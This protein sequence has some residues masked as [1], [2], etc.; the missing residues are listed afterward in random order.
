M[1]DAINKASVTDEKPEKPKDQES[2]GKILCSD[3]VRKIQNPASSGI[4]S[5][6]TDGRGPLKHRCLFYRFLRLSPDRLFFHMPVPACRRRFFVIGLRK[7]TLQRSDHVLVPPDFFIFLR[8]A[9]HNHRV[10][11][12]GGKHLF[13]HF[14]RSVIMIEQYRPNA[15]AA[16]TADAAR[17]RTA[18]RICFD[19]RSL[20]HVFR[21]SVTQLLKCRRRIGL[22]AS[23]DRRGSTYR[24]LVDGLVHA[25]VL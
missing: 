21:Q 17:K 1:V 9:E 24:L 14:M 5:P 6:S 18:S 4:H 7:I 15:D 11:G 25:V 8:E 22:P 3:L 13:E 12:V 23:A 20:R 16:K 10:I 19:K 2:D